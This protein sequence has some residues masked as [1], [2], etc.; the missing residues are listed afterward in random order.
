MDDKLVLLPKLF[1]R[2]IDY[3]GLGT[4][5]ASLDGFEEFLA[6]RN[7]RVLVLPDGQLTGLDTV[8]QVEGQTVRLLHPPEN[9]VFLEG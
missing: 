2:L 7:D 3:F 4:G 6:A 9:L 8:A 5:S 1:R